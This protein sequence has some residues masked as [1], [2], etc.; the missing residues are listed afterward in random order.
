MSDFLLIL[1]IAAVL[2][3]CAFVR[4]DDYRG[5]SF[6]LIACLVLAII[7]ESLKP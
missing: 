5:A 6:F 1:S 7:A 4:R 3:S 2:I